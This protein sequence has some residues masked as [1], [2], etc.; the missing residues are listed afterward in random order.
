MNAALALVFLACV[1]GSMAADARSQVFGQLVQQGQAVVQAVLGQLQQQ[2]LQIVQ[3]AVGQLSSL[4]GSMGRLTID[5]SNIP[6]QVR[7]IVGNL[8]NQVLVQL[9]GGLQGILGGKSPTLSSSLSPSSR[10]VGRASVDLGAIFSGF[11]SEIQGALTGI[12]Q[13]FLN[14]GLAA[15]LGGIAGSRGISDIFACEYLASV[16]V[17]VNDRPIPL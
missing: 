1:T 5:V 12:G 7:P 9:L 11:L 6:D 3:Q 16:Y 14:Q 15:V 13:H 10:L 4:V 2:V 17:H 8:I